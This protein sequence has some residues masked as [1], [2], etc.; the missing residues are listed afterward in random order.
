[1]PSRE[2][3]NQSL[4]LTPFKE[5]N[6][7]DLKSFHKIEHIHSSILHPRISLMKVYL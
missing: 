6:K 4:C 7:V 2:P 3:L 1:M 5:P